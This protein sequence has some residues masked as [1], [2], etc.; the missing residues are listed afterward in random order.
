MKIVIDYRNNKAG[1][2]MKRVICSDDYI[3]AMSNIRGIHV[4]NPNNLPFSFYFS[5]GKNAPHNIRVKPMF[6]PAK[7]KESLT[8]TL[9]LCDDWEFKPGVND[10]NV[11]PDK[12]AAMKAFFRRYIVLFCAVWDEQMQD[13]ILEDYFKGEITFQEMLEDLD[14]F[15]EY[16]EEL[17]AIST[18]E[19]LEEF[20]RIN[21]L[22]NFYGN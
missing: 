9:K 2:Y 20:C 16:T 8:G 7:L 13:G 11:K 18:V 15:D 21:N 1:D 10:K 22:V 5:S 19:E 6:N 17:S 12:I 14:F 3:L 4:K